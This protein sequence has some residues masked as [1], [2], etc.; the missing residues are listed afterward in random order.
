MKGAAIAA[1]VIAA[2]VIVAGIAAFMMMGSGSNDNGNDD[3]KTYTVSFVTDGGSYVSSQSV[4]Q[5]D[6]A[7][8]P[9]TSRAGYSFQGWFTSQNGGSQFSFSQSINKDTTLYAHWIPDQTPTTSYTITFN[10]NGGSPST[11]Q[12]V[13][14][15]S[16]ANEP[17]V[18]RSGY[19]FDGWY[20]AASGGSK[21]NFSNP[22]ASNMTL[23]AHWTQN[24]TPVTTYTVTFNA[25]G[26]S[27][28]SSQ[29]VNSGDKITEPTTTRSG[30][31]FLGWFTAS[32]GG[33]QF[34]FSKPITYDLTLYAHW[35]STYHTV[36]FRTN[37]N[38]T[39]SPTSITVQDGATISANGS[40]LTV[41]GQRIVA[42]PSA[43]TSQ[44]TY[45]FT[46]WSV[47]SGTVRSDMTITA[48][49]TVITKSYTVTFNS[50]GGSSVPSQT[51][52]A[53][54]YASVPSDPILSGYKFEGW[55]TSTGGSTKFNFGSP[56]T[57]NTT[58]YAQWTK[59]VQ[60][61]KFYLADRPSTIQIGSGYDVADIYGTSGTVSTSITVTPRSNTVTINLHNASMKSSGSYPLISADGVSLKIVVD[62][63][64]SLYGY[65]GTSATTSGGNGII[66]YSAVSCKSLALS[67]NGSIYIKGGN[68][69]NGYCLLRR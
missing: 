14:A 43:S 18:S 13:T 45:T 27:Y 64:C 57:A 15:G 63:S 33:E 62:G 3:V 11:S 69:G 39:V 16:Y 58:V 67:G 7:V 59:E 49:F 36:I 66:G 37:G 47:S 19:T 40:T 50:N 61:I 35:D 53:G 48:S 5:G 46:G 22:I 32:S 44:N 2:V 30:Y 52:V 23:Y 29:T 9:T 56:I 6:R 41:G 1:I 8:E 51:V 26:G 34:N 60:S 25:N 55:Y 31:N 54:G 21:F 68:G 17:S 20:T 10:A 65:D 38:G 4:K 12:T 42:N 28:V 24:S